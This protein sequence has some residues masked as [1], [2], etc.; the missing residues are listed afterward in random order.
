MLELLKWQK[1]GKERLEIGINYSEYENLIDEMSSFSCYFFEDD[2]NG[3]W[4]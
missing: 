4:V 1:Q 2:A 3:V